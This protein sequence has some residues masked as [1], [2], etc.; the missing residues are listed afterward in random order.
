[1]RS[2]REIELDEH[3]VLVRTEWTV[4]PPGGRTDGLSLASA[5]LLRRDG[6]EL[7]I[8]A[9]LNH[10]DIR[11][12]LRPIGDL[13]HAACSAVTRSGSGTRTDAPVLQ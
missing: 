13:R 6:D 4:Q 10:Q 2:S 9:Y 7:R 5:F 11:A 3:H 8:V 1:L 12:A